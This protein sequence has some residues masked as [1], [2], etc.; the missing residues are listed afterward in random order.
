MNLA[1]KTA[2]IFVPDHLPVEKALARTTHMGIGAHPD[3]LE[4]MAL[5]GILECYWSDQNWFTGVTIT[6]GSRSVRASKYA[7]YTGEQMRAVRR[8][9]QNKAAVLGEYSTMVCLDYPSSAIKE[10]SHRG[11][12]EDLKAL[13]SATSPGIIYTHNPADKHDTHIAVVMAVI[14]ALRELPEALRKKTLYGCE[15]WR[16]L[17][18]MLDE[19]KIVLDV[20]AGANLGVSLMGVYDSQ[21]FGGKRY[22]LATMGRKHA[23][24]TFLSSHGTDQATLLEYAMDL[25]PLIHNP[26]LDIAGYVAGFINRFGE[27]VKGKISRHPGR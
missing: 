27:D 23:N 11:L 4:F 2:E 5:H 18:W 16:G 26:S 15:V 14:Q 24:A 7:D 10:P 17:D 21:V 8:K 25:T 9:E 6:D 13:L 22:D 12:I 3:D 1:N 20:S 19:E